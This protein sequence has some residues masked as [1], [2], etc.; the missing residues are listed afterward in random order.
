[1]QRKT[2]L[3][4][5]AGLVVVGAG[6]WIVLDGSLAGWVRARLNIKPAVRIDFAALSGDDNRSQAL[7][8]FPGTK[9]LCRQPVPDAVQEECSMEVAKV[10]GVPATSLTLYFDQDRLTRVRVAFPA[11]EHRAFMTEVRAVH[12]MWSQLDQR[13]EYG[14]ALV[15]WTLPGGRL[16]MSE[17]ALSAPEAVALWTSKAGLFRDTVREISQL[18]QSEANLAQVVATVQVA[19]GGRERRYDTISPFRRSFRRV[20][21]VPNEYN[22]QLIEWLLAN[23][24][25]VPSPLL[26]ELAQRLQYTDSKE[27]MRWFATFRLLVSYDAARCVDPTASSGSGAAAVL[28]LYPVLVR[29]AEENPAALR[30]AKAAARNWARVRQIRSSPMWLC[31]TAMRAVRVNG[32]GQPMPVSVRE[33]MLPESKWPAAWRDVLVKSEP[34]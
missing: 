31:S 13:D 14:A 17:E 11:G 33:L 32:Q 2:I 26:L 10:N 19:G 7:A 5:V 15:V 24:E 18:I 3:L 20:R 12:G 23:A 29:Q 34:R 21:A 1:M 6:A 27:A 8:R 28:A 25:T 16:M 4:V 22:A 9:P 30:D